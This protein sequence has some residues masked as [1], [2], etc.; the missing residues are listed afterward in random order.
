MRFRK[1]EPA[2]ELLRQA[3]ALDPEN[4]MLTLHERFCSG[5][6]HEVPFAQAA[7]D[8][9]ALEPKGKANQAERLY[10]AGWLWK[11]AGKEKKAFRCFQET[12][13]VDPNNVDA[14]REVRLLQK[15]MGEGSEKRELNIPF[16]RFFKKK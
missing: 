6:L 7:K 2:K 12:L 14:K 15:R 11:L 13:S 1:W 16:G 10:R 3:Q 9:E 4:V 5:I 8:I